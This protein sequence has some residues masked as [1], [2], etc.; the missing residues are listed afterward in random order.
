MVNIDCNYYLNVAKLMKTELPKP[1]KKLYDID[2][3]RLPLILVES[4]V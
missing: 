3:S 4:D 1:S 2:G